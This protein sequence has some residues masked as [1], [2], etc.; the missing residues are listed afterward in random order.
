MISPVSI[1]S[2]FLNASII[3]IF[4]G[5]KNAS[6]KLILSSLIPSLVAKS[7]KVLLYLL[8]NSFFQFGYLISKDLSISFLIFEK[9]TNLTK[10][11]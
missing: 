7:L 1:D 11:E 6:V 2:L 4:G 8:F 10:E 5:F 9:S 3:S